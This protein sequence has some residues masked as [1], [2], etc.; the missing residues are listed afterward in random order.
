MK[1]IAFLFV[2]TGALAV[3]IGM[4]WGIKMSMD[5]DFTLSAAHAHL[6]LIGFVVMTIYGFYYHMVPAAAE[7][8]LAKIHYV[9]ALAGVV[10]I[11]PGIVQAIQETGE[12]LAKVGSTL[13]LAG[14]LIFVVTILTNRAQD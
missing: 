9:V 10:I 4:A 3:T 13:V 7:K 5:A 11:V 14:M 2:L 1:G 6:N 12:T 8:M